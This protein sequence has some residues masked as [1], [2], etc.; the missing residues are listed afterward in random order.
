MEKDYKRITMTKEEFL[1]TYIF[2]GLTDLNDGFDAETIKYFTEQDFDK[3]LDRVEKYG[4]SI[5][6]IEPWQDGE[7]YDC[8]VFESYEDNYESAADPKWYR[9]VFEG[10]IVQG[11]VLQYAASYGVPEELL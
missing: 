6:G 3:V 7:Y 8:K 1:D 2:E 4:L 9:S 11:E 10:F 5:Y